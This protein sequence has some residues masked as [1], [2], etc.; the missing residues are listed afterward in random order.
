LN[1]TKATTTAA[2]PITTVL[3]VRDDMTG[4]KPPPWPV[5]LIRSG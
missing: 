5:R 2:T 1:T 4:S 3:S